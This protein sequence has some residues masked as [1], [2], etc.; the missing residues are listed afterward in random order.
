MEL[1]ARNGQK[2][3]PARSLGI[4]TPYRRQIALIRKCL[5]EE[6]LPEEI[7]IDTV[8]RYQGSQR[9]VIIYSFAL[10][11]SR[12]IELLQNNYF[13]PETGARVDR[14]LNVAITRARQQLIFLG[15]EGVLGTDLLYFRLFEYIKTRG[16]YVPEGV[17]GLIEN[18]LRV[19]GE[20]D[21]SSLEG[22]IYEPDPAF[23]AVFE[24]VV[25]QPIR[26]RSVNFP[27]DVLRFS[28]AVCRDQLI[29]YGRA[30]F[31]QALLVADVRGELRTVSP[32]DR[33]LAYAYFNQRKH[34]FSAYAIFEQYRELFVPVA[35]PVPQRLVFFDIGCGPLTS[36]LAFQQSLSRENLAFQFRYVGI[37]VSP[38][39]LSLATEFAG[40]ALF[41]NQPRP[42]LLPSLDDLPFDQLDDWFAIP[43]T[44]VFNGSY[45]FANLTPRQADDLAERLNAL[46]DRYPLNRYV[47]VHQNPAAEARNRNYQVFKKALSSRFRR[48]A[49]STETV[50][51]RNQEQSFYDKSETVFYE[52]LS[53]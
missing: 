4:I 53:T 44:V 41:E 5:R 20:P 12:Q 27:K 18:R 36:G 8:E 32:K 3:D 15:D 35:R 23:A 40:T 24:R 30:I 1:Y 19:V 10:S 7:T 11:N 13:D 39:M 45:L 29:E 21:E 50:R 6:G 46:L 14:K 37:D 33:V 22:K 34:Y 38:A 43:H 48:R 42:L 25:L 16:G 26:S 28:P 49:S 9:D 2:F 31:E 52:I 47:Y 51:Y 17:A